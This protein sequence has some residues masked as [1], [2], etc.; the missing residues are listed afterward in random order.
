MSDSYRTMRGPNVIYVGNLPADIK[1]KELQELFD[2]VSCKASSR[3]Y[4]SL[5]PLRVAAVATVP[6][7]VLIFIAQFGPIRAIDIKVPP[8]PPPFAFIEFQDPRCATSPGQQSY[9]SID[10]VLIHSAS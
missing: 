7:P 1:E 8:R 2:K 10:L 3:L 9:P 5:W 4:C 6:D